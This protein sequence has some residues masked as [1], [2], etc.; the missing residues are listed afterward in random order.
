MCRNFIIVVIFLLG[1]IIVANAEKSSGL[2]IDDGL[3]ETISDSV[4]L[5]E[6]RETSYTLLNILEEYIK[7]REIARNVQLVKKSAY[8]CLLNIYKNVLPNES[9]KSR[10]FYDKYEDGYDINVNV[11]DQSDFIITF[12]AY[13]PYSGNAS[14]TNRG[15]RIW[16]NV[17]EAPQGQQIVSAQ[18][19]LYHSVGNGRAYTVEVYRVADMKSGKRIKEY[20]NSVNTTADKVGWITVDISQA[21]KYWVNHPRKNRGLHIVVYDVDYVGHILRPDDIGIVGLSGVPEKQPF[22]VGFFRSSGKRSRHDTLRREKRDSRQELGCSGIPIPSKESFQNRVRNSCKKKSL[23]MS[24]KELKWHNS[25]L[26]PDGVDA[27][28]CRGQCDYPLATR[29]NASMHAIAQAQLHIIKPYVVPM[30]CCVPS[31]LSPIHVLYLLDDQ[32][33]ALKK[34]ENMVIDSCGCY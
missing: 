10:A 1:S 17:S 20:I 12:G 29:K 4:S 26:A 28:Y 27:F 2:Y 24:F 30:P 31:K 32:T 14:K 23:Y 5:K 19:K 34:F 22:V 21:L 3:N 18:L 25:I 11:I 16:F 9:N 6:K 33:I 7:P 8:K 13:N 15:K